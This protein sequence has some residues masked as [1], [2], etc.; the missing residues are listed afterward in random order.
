MNVIMVLADQ[1]H[2]EMMGCAGHPQAITPQLDRFAEESVRFSN[3][4]CQNPICTPSRVSILSGQ[5]PH[6]T[7]YYGLSGP[8]NAGLDNLFRHY[9]KHGYKTAGYG[10]M[11]LPTY[12]RNW[13]ADDLDDFC[14]SYETRDGIIGQSDYLES[15]GLRHLEDS[16]H[17]K[18]H[19]GEKSISLDSMPSELPYEDTLEMWHLAR[20]QQFMEAS[21]GQPFFIQMCF[22]KPHHP[23][24]PQKQFW[25]MY[26]EDIELP[27]TYQ[28]DVSSRPPHF[29]EMNKIYHEMDWD[30]AKSKDEDSIIGM[31]RAW[32]GTLA[33]VTQIDDVFGRLL[34]YLDTKGLSENTIVIYG[35]DHG[36]YHG[37]HGIPE[38]A[39][40]ICSD[41]VCKVPYIWRVPGAQANGTVS[42]ALVENLDMASTLP[43]LCDLPAMEAVDGVNLSPLLDQTSSSVRDEA[44]TENMRSKSI[45][46]GK[47]R[48]VHY[49]RENFDGED[50]GELYDVENDPHE[51]CNLY[52]DP[53]HQET[54]NECR[55]RIID[56]LTRTTRPL[57]WQGSHYECEGDLLE[58]GRPSYP[59]ASDGT[60][61]DGHS[62]SVHPPMANYV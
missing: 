26:P 49:A 33:C 59:I 12:P 17:N 36:C 41:A 18:N 15:K 45:R 21:E 19:Y 8:S 7:G 13:V 53:S 4:Y 47:W 42:D 58:R 3:A 50:I 44:V 46:W 34:D 62:P 23:L 43:K 60:A 52:K 25:D 35:S 31:R 55:R 37:I 6:N 14:D 11:H 30:Y 56:W 32:R 54:V 2:A 27:G 38:K 28:Q 29:R 61:P 10:K 40:G 48:F 51:T 24:L 57:T 1:H 16:W 22:Q 39:P 20:A 5:Y 9:K